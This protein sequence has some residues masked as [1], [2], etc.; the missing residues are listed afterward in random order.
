MA[1]FHSRL[2]D[3]VNQD[4]STTVTHVCIIL[5]SILTKGLLAPFLTTVLNNTDGC[6]K[7][8]R[9]EYAIYLLSCIALEYCIIIDRTVGA[10]DHGKYVV[11]GLNYIDKLMLKLSM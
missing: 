3:E 1:Q 10:T 5:Q 7:Q 6:A 2:S 8:Y 9:C 4:A 11:D